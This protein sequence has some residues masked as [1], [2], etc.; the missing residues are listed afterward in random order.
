[1]RGTSI[2]ILLAAGIALSACGANFNSIGRRTTLPSNQQAAIHLDAQQRVV[3]VGRNGVYC[4]EPSPD[5]M[6]AY[7]QAAA[8]GVSIVGKGA[9]SGAGSSQSDISDIGLRTQSITLMR[10]ALYR[11]CEAGANGQLTDISQ[12]QL[13]ARSQDLTAVVVAVEQLTGAVAANQS[14]LT[15]TSNAS[16]SASL[17]SDAAQLDAARKNLTKKNEELTAAITARDTQQTVVTNQTATVAAAQGRV[18][19]PPAGADPV[20]LQKTL[21]DEKTAL[22]RE[23]GKLDVAISKVIDAQKAVDDAQQVVNTIEAKN[24][25]A[26]TSATA[27]TTGSGQFSTPVQR[28]QLDKASSEKIA[29]SVEGMVTAVL[30]KDYTAADC[31]FLLTNITKLGNVINPT[32]ER[33]LNNTL[34]QCGNLLNAKI[35]NEISKLSVSYFVDDDSSKKLKVAMAKDATL[36]PKIQAWLQTNRPD[37]IVPRL[38]YGEEN[39]AVRQ[40]VISDLQ[41]Q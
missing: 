41:I 1:M 8:L 23:Q 10:D 31:M 19:S 26:L 11:L 29:A 12:T 36:L 27:S 7:A 17:I 22:Q 14:L 16:S 32:Q 18:D 34:D 6:A 35:N 21:Q 13:M 39:G 2:L 9:G 38:I 40:Q 30:N 20:A 15:G 37:L 33:L 25:A 28:V 5:A 4:A 3:M 24:S